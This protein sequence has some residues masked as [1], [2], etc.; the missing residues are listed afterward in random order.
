[1]IEV[2]IPAYNA[3]RFLRETLQSVAAQTLLPGRVTVV[4]DASTDDTVAVAHACRDELAGRI[5]IRVMA[6]AGPRGPSA[7]RNTAIRQSEAEWIALLDADDLIAVT[8]HASLLRAASTASDVVL[9]FGDS[10]I[11]LDDGTGPRRTLL[12]SFFSTSGVSSLPATELA[13]GCLTLGDATFPAL[14]KHGLFGTSAC[15]FRREAAVTA[16]LFDESMI[17]AEDTD[18]FLRL[19]LCGRFAFTREVTTLKR[20]HD[21]NLTQHRN[22]LAFCHGVAFSFCKL[23]ARTDAPLLT[24]QQ[25]TAVNHAVSRAVEAYLYQT[26]RYGAVAYGRAARLAWRSGRALMAAAP[27]HLVRLA[28]HR[29]IAGR[30]G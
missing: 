25:R 17:Y 19:A 26:S 3:G 4:D 30:R 21:D 1:V 8:H 13:P 18:F 23:A 14:L 29:A 15:L 27:R 10:E 2:V 22:H 12:S 6:N 5:Q 28:I 24:A 20:V 16:R 7:A 11:F 9:G